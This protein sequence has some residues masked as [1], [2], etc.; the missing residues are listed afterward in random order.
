MSHRLI[1]YLMQGL[2]DRLDCLAEQPKRIAWVQEQVPDF[3]WPAS[4]TVMSLSEALR[5]SD[6]YDALVVSGALYDAEKLS[7]HLSR[8]TQRLQEGG[9]LFFGFYALDTLKEYT[10]ALHEVGLPLLQPFLDMHDVADIVMGECITDVVSDNDTLQLPVLP[11]DEWVMEL[12]NAMVSPVLDTLALSH[13]LSL[14]QPS[15]IWVN[16]SKPTTIEMGFIHG[17]Y[18]PKS[19]KKAAGVH[20]VSID[21][22]G[23]RRSI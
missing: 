19:K 5:H 9:S 11:V 3:E 20:T 13:E 7:E 2:V 4:V 17:I 18:Q 22:I 21:A 6:R 12:S 15:S 14:P 8:L 16:A 1:R 23:G 10:H